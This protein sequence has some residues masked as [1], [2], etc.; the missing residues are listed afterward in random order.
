[1]ATHLLSISR[2]CH[3]QELFCLLIRCLVHSPQ[4]PGLSA[5]SLY[6]CSWPPNK[7]FFPGFTIFPPCG[8]LFPVVKSAK[9]FPDSGPL[10][11]LSP[12]LECFLPPEFLLIDPV[13]AQISSLHKGLLWR[14]SLFNV[15][16][17]IL[18]LALF[19]SSWY[20]MKLYYLGFGGGVFCLFIFPN[21]AWALW[22]QAIY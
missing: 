7:L 20:Y 19:Y 14:R 1:M 22:G 6:P 17:Y 18:P 15:L 2:V 3:C 21:R 12:H 16:N 10:H 5:C 11:L 4:P 8:F 13:S 9:L